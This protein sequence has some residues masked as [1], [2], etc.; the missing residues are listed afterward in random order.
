[1][2]LYSLDIEEIPSALDVYDEKLLVGMGRKL[3][4]YEV[5]RNKLVLRA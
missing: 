1:M 4:L 5:T 3:R 2:F